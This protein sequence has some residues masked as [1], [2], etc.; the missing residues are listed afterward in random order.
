MLIVYN[1]IIPCPRLSYRILKMV[2]LYYQLEYS[3]HWGA[4]HWSLSSMDIG[5]CT[6][7]F[8]LIINII[9]SCYQH[10]WVW[11]KHFLSPDLSVLVGWNAVILRK[12]FTLMHIRSLSRELATMWRTTKRKK[13]VQTFLIQIKAIFRIHL[14]WFRFFEILKPCLL[15]Q[16]LW[17][18]N[19]KWW[20]SFQD[21]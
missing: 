5:I 19:K 20:K 1:C 6:Y 12:H 2:Y 3:H 10:S 21:V 7:I 17:T 11:M 14:E 4:L 13:W 18:S 16:T 15:H 9:V 8:Y